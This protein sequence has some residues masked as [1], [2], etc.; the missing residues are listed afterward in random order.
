MSLSIT[1]RLAERRPG[2]SP[3]SCP[4]SSALRWMLRD[5][6][7]TELSGLSRTWP[8]AREA[9]QTVEKRPVEVRLLLFECLLDPFILKQ[10]APCSQ[11]I[12]GEKKNRPGCGT[13]LRTLILGKALRPP[14]KLRDL[15]VSEHQAIISDTLIDA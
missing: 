4:L 2:H 3:H 14:L 8:D 9:T 10:L 5:S 11:E 1:R 13:Q 6:F 15:I 7:S 12:I